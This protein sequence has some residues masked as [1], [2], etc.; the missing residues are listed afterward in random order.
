MSN[1]AKPPSP[2]TYLAVLIMLSVLGWAIFLEYSDAT[3]QLNN[4]E[5]ATGILKQA[6]VRK[7]IGRTTLYYVEFLLV[8]D[9]ELFTLE[10]GTGVIRQ[11]DLSQVL[12]SNTALTIYFEK[13]NRTTENKVYQI[14]TPSQVVYSIKKVH[15]N[16]VGSIVLLGFLAAFIVMVPFSGYFF[17]PTNSKENN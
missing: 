9:A 15:S 2:A 12:P 13:I 6:E 14:E 4:L 11:E 7:S 17:N 10:E 5:K 3:K 16:A 8:D 1:Y